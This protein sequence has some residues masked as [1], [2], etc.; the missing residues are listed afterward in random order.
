MIL[1]VSV[2]NVRGKIDLE[3]MVVR[4]QEEILQQVA[5]GKDRGLETEATIE[6][7]RAP[8]RIV[9][10]HLLLVER[11]ADALAAID[12]LAEAE[13]RAILEAPSGNGSSLDTKNAL[14]WAPAPG[15]PGSVL[16][17]MIPI[18]AMVEGSAQSQLATV[19][20]VIIALIAAIFVANF[21]ARDFSTAIDALKLHFGRISE[22]NL[23]VSESYEAEDDLGDLARS[24]EEMAYSLQSAIALVADAANQ[25]EATGQAIEHASDQVDTTA[26]SQAQSIA[27]VSREMDEINLRSREISGSAEVLTQAVNASSTAVLQLDQ[28]SRGLHEHSSELDQQVTDAAQ[29]MDEMSAK[30]HEVSENTRALSDVASETVDRA[31]Q[32]VEQSRV[33]EGSATES[34]ALFRRV[35]T[36]AELGSRQVSD[37]IDGTKVIHGSVGEARRVVRSLA[38]RTEVI[39]SIVTVIEEIA[40]ESSLLA[41]NAAII[42]A[43]AGEH[44]RAFSVVADQTKG[45]AQQVRA[46]AREIGDIVT[47]VTEEAGQAVN[48]IE[49]GFAAVDRGVA[50]SGEA[51]VALDAVTVAIGESGDRIHEIV[52]AV[53]QQSRE[54]AEVSSVMASLNS[55]L[56]RIRDSS[57][58][59]ARESQ[60]IAQTSTAIQEIARSVHSH[61]E[62]Q[63]ASTKHITS[64]VDEVST[65]TAQ[66]NAA[67][68]AQSEACGQVVAFLE[69]M[70]SQTEA[71]TDS[72]SH[73]KQTMSSLSEQAASL[74]SM[75]ARFTLSSESTPDS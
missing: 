69:G 23:T 49:N 65:S 42:A 46:R 61:A 25:V 3:R 26:N 39:D 32:M 7:L 11:T 40:D 60:R 57:E 64:N 28:V 47:A 4:G 20:L 59:Q 63:A 27:R 44:G 8:A 10:H 67:L 1:G 70:T 24:V 50:L 43:Q 56:A 51:G 29:S 30:I 66:I 21:I 16:L 6:T 54:S 53:H 13:R 2:A 58:K 72:A 15:D 55:E 75:V 34:D 14:S 38:E 41:L 12:A 31:D 18:D 36:S 52:G 5:S 48:L 45:L 71:A 22:G 37:T 9:A 68:A 17:A 62:D 33:V 19:G 73:L 35:V 74:R